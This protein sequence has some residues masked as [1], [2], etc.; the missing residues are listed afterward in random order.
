VQ[1]YS[2]STQV[3]SAG[4]YFRTD[5]PPPPSALTG[6]TVSVSG[7]APNATVTASWDSSSNATGYS[8]SAAGQSGAVGSGSLSKTITVSTAG[9]YSFSVTPY[10]NTGNGSGQTRSFTVLPA[11]NTPTLSGAYNNTTVTLTVG[12]MAS[13]Q[14]DGVV[15]EQRLASND[16][17]V[18]S[19]IVTVNGGYV[20][21]TI[22]N[23]SIKNYY[24]RAYA[25]L[26]VN[27]TSGYSGYSNIVAYARPS[28]WAWATSKI[29][30]QPIN[31]T[32]V[33]WN[34][35]TSRINEFRVYRGLSTY[36]FTTVSKG[37]DI[38]ASIFNQ[39]VNAINS[40][41]PNPS[42]TSATA[43]VTVISASILNGIRNSL[44]S[45]D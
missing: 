19:K 25:Y 38:T 24:F 9:S 26:N 37:M 3:G 45:I 33:E 23:S 43:K 36:S 41:S 32:A 4:G 42:A 12:G 21:W 13:G 35:F 20:Q 8:W 18:D 27:G 31:L 39:A 14:W 16:S 11:P 34:N 2:G 6:L 29:S 30:G 44:N 17:L 1:Y 15:V 28:D 7:T 22:P 40:M 10:N 5:P